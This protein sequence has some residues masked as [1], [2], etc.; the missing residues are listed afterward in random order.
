MKFRCMFSKQF[1]HVDDPPAIKLANNRYMYVH[2]REAEQKCTVSGQGIP[3]TGRKGQTLG[4]M[5][6]AVPKGHLEA[7]RA[8][9]QLFSNQ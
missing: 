1:Y 8:R 5:Y 6:T 9:E 7:V 4:P 3:T 2:T